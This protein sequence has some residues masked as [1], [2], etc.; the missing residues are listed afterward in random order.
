M[1]TPPL[2][3]DHLWTPSARICTALLATGHL[4]QSCP[5]PSVALSYLLL[6]GLW[7]LSLHLFLLAS[8]WGSLRGVFSWGSQ[9]CTRPPARRSKPATIPPL[10]THTPRPPLPAGRALAAQPVSAS[11]GRPER[12]S[13]ERLTKAALPGLE[14]VGFLARIPPSPHPEES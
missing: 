5:H 3:S 1:P 7:L 11:T 13:P 9:I 4:P 8:L 14:P 2:I 10:H 6:L 12:S